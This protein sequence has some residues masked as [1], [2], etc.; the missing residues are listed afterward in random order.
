VSSRACSKDTRPASARPYVPSQASRGDWLDHVA[1]CVEV[2]KQRGARIK[3]LRVSVES[4][5]PIGAGISSS[6]ALQVT[7]LRAL[8]HWLRLDVGEEEIARLARRAEAEY[9]GVPSAI[10][11]HMMSALGKPGQAMFLDTR[12]LSR[13]LLPLPSGCAIAVAHSGFYPESN[14]RH[15]AAA[16]LGLTSLRD[17]NISDHG[18]VEALTDPLNSRAR[19]IV[20]ENG[21]VIDGVEALRSADLPAFGS[22]MVDSYCSQRDDYQLSVPAVDALVEAALRHGALGA[23]LTGDSFGGSVVALLN[24]HMIWD[25]WPRVAADCPD[26]WLIYPSPGGAGSGHRAG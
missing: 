8:G 24:R 13:E 16:G 14:E 1:G 10:M 22:L 5:V 6:A 9:V 17:I 2:L 25:W 3:S 15:A 23:R 4:D 20:T 21:R 7:T 19:H 12:D 11:D 18:S 26:A